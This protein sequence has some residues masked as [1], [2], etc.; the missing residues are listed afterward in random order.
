MERLGGSERVKVEKTIRE[1][2]A[3]LYS[4]QSIPQRH[5]AAENVLHSRG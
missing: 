2:L 1:T 3:S 5:D 4:G